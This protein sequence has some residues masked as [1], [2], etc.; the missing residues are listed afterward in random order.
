M[1]HRLLIAAALLG[2]AKT[3]EVTVPVCFHEAEQRTATR[4]VYERVAKIAK[5]QFC[6][7]TG[8]CVGHCAIDGWV[9]DV[10]IHCRLGHVVRIE[11]RHV[12]V[13]DVGEHGPQALDDLAIDDRATTVTD[14]VQG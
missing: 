7:V 3:R 12:D 13:F 6:F 8:H 1:I 2:I 10:Q 11:G 5:V 4:T 9:R 14:E